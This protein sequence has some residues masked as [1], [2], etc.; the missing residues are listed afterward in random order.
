MARPLSPNPAPSDEPA[1]LEPALAVLPSGRRAR[2]RYRLQCRTKLGAGDIDELWREWAEGDREH[3]EIRFRGCLSEAMADDSP[4]GMVWWLGQAFRAATGRRPTTSGA[5]VDADDDDDRA[6][7]EIRSGL[8]VRFV[9]H[10]VR[11]ANPDIPDADLPSGFAI[12]EALQRMR[13]GWEREL[14]PYRRHLPQRRGPDN[15]RF[16]LNGTPTRQPSRRLRPSMCE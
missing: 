14:R 3:F 9:R 11:R 12:E 1:V 4:D 6:V 13:E 10:V 5:L 15:Q 2:V 7:I 8:F 16:H